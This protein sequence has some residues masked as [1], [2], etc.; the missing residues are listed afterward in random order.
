MPESWRSR[1]ACSDEGGLQAGA[2]LKAS[3][4]NPEEN[5]GT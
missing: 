3:N 5:E 1:S 4:L 2:M